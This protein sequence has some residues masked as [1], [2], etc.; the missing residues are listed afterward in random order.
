MLRLSQIEIHVATIRDFETKVFVSYKILHV[1][2]ALNACRLTESLNI[3]ILITGILNV[4]QEVV[5]LLLTTMFCLI[6]ASVCI[7]NVQYHAIGNEPYL[8]DCEDN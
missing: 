2:A 8:P 7:H 1:V 3:D 4:L 6:A 5:K